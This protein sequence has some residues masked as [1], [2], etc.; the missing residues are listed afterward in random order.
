M[1]VLV[2]ESQPHVRA[3]LRFLL[4]RQ[5]DIQ[6]VGCIGAEPDLA[7]RLSLIPTDII[8]LDWALPRHTA[9]HLLTVLRR[10]PDQPRTVVLSSTQHAQ[11]AALAAGADAVVS[12]D[13]EPDA[14][15]RILR[16][17]SVKRRQPGEPDTPKL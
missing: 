8:I 5:S 17:V 10:L 3:A 6:C 2:V 9:S 16:A 13:D 14:V 4:S 11:Q 1:R 7:A 15:L 12:M